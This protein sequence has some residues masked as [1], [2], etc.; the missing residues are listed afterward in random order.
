MAKVFQRVTLG[1]DDKLVLRSIKLVEP[2]GDE[3]EIRFTK[4]E[5]NAKLPASTFTP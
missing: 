4:V 2:S 1:F 3:K 5:R